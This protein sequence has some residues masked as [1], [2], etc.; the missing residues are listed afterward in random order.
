MLLIFCLLSFIVE[1]F[2]KA[3]LFA[4]L[5]KPSVTDR[6]TSTTELHLSSANKVSDIA[7]DFLNCLLSKRVLAIPIEFRRK[8]YM[9]LDTPR[10]LFWDDYRLL[11]EKIGLGP[12]VILFLGQRNNKIELI[13]QKFDAQED[14]SIRRFMAILKEMERNDV[15][16]V[17][18]QWMLYEWNNNNSSSANC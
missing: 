2:N 1:S 3:V 13:L 6:C 18:E 9:L 10:E 7:Q 16:T 15:V 17:I 4:A 5:E 8:I 11:A 14:P 12:D